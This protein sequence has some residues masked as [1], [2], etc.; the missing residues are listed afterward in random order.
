ME[1][2]T[3]HGSF[4]PFASHISKGYFASGTQRLF[5]DMIFLWVTDF[6]RNI[7]TNILKN[8]KQITRALNDQD[9]LIVHQIHF[10]FLSFPLE[11]LLHAE[12]VACDCFLSRCV[13]VVCVISI[14]GLL[15]NK[16]AFSTLFFSI[17]SWTQS[18]RLPSKI[19][20]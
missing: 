13:E 17:E 12:G 20:D 3:C 19:R 1:N 8:M 15:K 7:G 14:S 18:R 5:T 11:L 16:C 9:W 4:V 10:F 2:C 6:Y